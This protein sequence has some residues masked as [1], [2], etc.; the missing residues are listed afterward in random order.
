MASSKSSSIVRGLASLYFAAN[1]GGLATLAYELAHKHV[2]KAQMEEIG[3]MGAILV[4]GLVTHFTLA[5][6]S[7]IL[8]GSWQL[9]PEAIDRLENRFGAIGLFAALAILQAWEH[10]AAHWVFWFLSGSAVVFITAAV[11]LVG[12]LKELHP[13]WQPPAPKPAKGVWARTTGVMPA[14]LVLGGLVLGLIVGA[15][16]GFELFIAGIVGLGVGVVLAVMYTLI[17]LVRKTD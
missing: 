17:V 7:R 14:V 9:E 8:K 1:L 11:V 5:D 10:H 15:V 6:S 12:Q 4:Y 13:N 16:R 2:P 3:L